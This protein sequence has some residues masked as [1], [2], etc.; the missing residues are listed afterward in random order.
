MAPPTK[1]STTTKH[2][3]KVP[4][5]KLPIFL[6]ASVPNRTPYSRHS[7][8]IAIREAILALIAVAARERLIVFGGHPAISP[9]VEHAAR[10]LG[11]LHNIVIYQSRFF[12]SE[13]PKEARAF[14]HFHWTKTRRNRDSSLEFMRSEMIRSQAFCAAVFIGGME[15][16]LD[17][18]RM[19][20]EFH[21]QSVILPIASTLG[22]AK[23]LFD[24][25]E[26]PEDQLIRQK[27]RDNTRYRALFR[28]ILP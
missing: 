8:P 16:I 20:K 25:G 2:P 11:A 15:G 19:F 10:S 18:S 9:L 7:D 1:R 3:R 21:P 28:I 26:G 4:S 5:P 14:Q 12:Q 23:K 24:S 13:V 17:E 22:A 6:S 27:L